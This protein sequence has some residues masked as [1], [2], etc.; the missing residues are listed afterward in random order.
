MKK[1]KV[2]KKRGYYGANYEAKLIFHYLDVDNDLSHFVPRDT[3][4]ELKDI[5]PFI[6]AHK[7]IN[8]KNHCDGIY[9]LWCQ[10]NFHGNYYIS[11][12]NPDDFIV[13]SGRLKKFISN[14][15][16][17][18]QSEWS[19]PNR[20]SFAITNKVDK[21]C[22]WRLDKLL[23]KIIPV[24]ENLMQPLQRISKR[25]NKHKITFR[26]RVRSKPLVWGL[27]N[28]YEEHS[29]ENPNVCSDDKF[30]KF[31]IEVVNKIHRVKCVSV[32]SSEE[33]LRD[34]IKQVLKER[35]KQKLITGNNFPSLI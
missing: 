8:I 2:K 9:Y 7:L 34:Y 30:Y 13:R 29:G 10:L 22:L 3:I 27:A 23:D 26:R 6:E 4:F 21:N 24:A 31:F 20:L 12:T 28:V 19:L 16:K 11:N 5:E 25:I 17:L 33:S 18:Q 14:A 1:E 32:I 35:E 15:K